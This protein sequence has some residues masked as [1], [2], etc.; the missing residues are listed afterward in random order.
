M[1]L[2]KGGEV[3]GRISRIASRVRRPWCLTL[4]LAIIIVIIIA[5]AVP[6][7]VILPGRHTNSENTIVLFPLYIYPVTNSTWNPLYEAF[8][9]HPQLNFTVIVNPQSG[10]GSSPYPTEQ[11]SFQLR[12]LHAYPNVRTVGYVRTGYAERNITAVLQDVA[13][14]SGWAS[15]SS[16]LAVDGIFFDEIPSEYSSTMAEYLST[17]NQAAKNAPGLQLDRMVIHNPGAI[18]DSRYNDTSTDIT[19]VFEDSYQAYQTK[20]ASLEALPRNRTE[21]AYMLHSVPTISADFVDQLSNDAEFL[22]LTTLSE[23]YYGSF[24]PQW[25]EFCDVVPT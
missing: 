3:H 2:E 7:A 20:Q 16:A 6:L 5:I 12:Q 13:T 1:A 19:V 8:T 10:P 18:P 4:V 17:I 21:Y 15:K 24:D 14:Y 22:F 9:A 25:A 23:N 11:Y